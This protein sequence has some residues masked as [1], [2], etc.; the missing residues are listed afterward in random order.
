MIRPYRQKG[1][2]EGPYY[3]S[4]NPHDVSMII[5]QM[6]KLAPRL[7]GGDRRRLDEINGKRKRVLVSVFVNDNLHVP[8]WYPLIIPA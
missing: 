3:E 4:S 7:I 2:E 1:E 6:G 5:E 8:S